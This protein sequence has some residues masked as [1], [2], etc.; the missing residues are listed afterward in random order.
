MR[1]LVCHHTGVAGDQT[2]ETIARYHVEHNGWPSIGYH[3]C[4]HPDGRI[5]YV[6]DFLTVRYNVAS[7]NL[8]CIGIC[9]IGDF[10]RSQPT[11]LALAATAEVTAYLKQEIPGVVVVGHREIT[12]P[13]WETTCPGNT[14][15]GGWKVAVA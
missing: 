1:W 10:T 11:A 13:G 9:V 12:V 5:E 4:I 15:L 8:F 3:L 6:G 14:F 2:A 7:Q